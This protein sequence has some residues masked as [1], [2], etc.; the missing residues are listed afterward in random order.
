MSRSER[1]NFFRCPYSG[2]LYSLTPGPQSGNALSGPTA[3]VERRLKSSSLV[4]GGGIH[5][6][7]EVL[8]K[9]LLN[10]TEPPED[11]AV[12]AASDYVRSCHLAHDHEGRP[13]SEFEQLEALNLVQALTIISARYVLPPLLTEYSIVEVEKEMSGTLLSLPDVSLVHPSRADAILESRTSGSLGLL[14]LKTSKYIE[15]PGDTTKTGRKIMDSQRIDQQG[16]SETWTAR[17]CGYPVDFVQFV[18]LRK[19]ELRLH[20][21]SGSGISPFYYYS[22]PLLTGWR[23]E[24]G[25]GSPT[26]AWAWEYLRNDDGVIKKSSLSWSKWKRFWI[27]EEGITP[28]EWI[29]RLEADEIFPPAHQSVEGKSPLASLYFISNPI[30]R[31]EEEIEEWLVQTQAFDQRTLSSYLQI[32]SLSPDIHKPDRLEI[33]THFPRNRSACLFPSRCQ[34]FEHCHEGASIHDPFI[35]EGLYIPRI[36]NHKE[37]Q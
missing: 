8:L 30:Y 12:E 1:E 36:D 37:N 11:E 27:W 32:Q 7:W 33:L 9:G 2:Y 31:T 34:Y 21:T 23:S 25:F 22:L 19:G 13:L 10:S 24:S 17:Q 35:Q 6:G 29:N 15:R 5:R 18:T 20:E 3:G 4:I 28:K 14:S 26:Y 16:I